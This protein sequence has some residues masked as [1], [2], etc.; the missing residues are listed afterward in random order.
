[1]WSLLE[2]VQPSYA[3]CPTFAKRSQTQSWVVKIFVL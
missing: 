3:F 2:V 1:M